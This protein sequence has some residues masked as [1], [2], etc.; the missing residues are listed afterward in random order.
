MP[1]VSPEM[2]E[3]DL[4]RLVETQKKFVEAEE[5]YQQAARERQDLFLELN[6][7]GGYTFS[8]IASM[9]D[10]SHQTVISCAMK[11]RRRLEK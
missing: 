3:K 11:A 5:A 10:I 7:K 2:Q 9:I 6:K 1:R 8:A 4:T